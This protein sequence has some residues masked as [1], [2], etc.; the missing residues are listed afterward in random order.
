VRN[1]NAGSVCVEIH[2]ER[3]REK[4]ERRAHGDI[5]IYIHTERKMS[6]DSVCVLI[7]LTS[8]IVDVKLSNK[9]I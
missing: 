6:E 8:S 5:Y 7:S 4:N 1:K 2:R 9:C 3:E